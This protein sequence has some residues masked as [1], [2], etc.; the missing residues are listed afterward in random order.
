M[1]VTLDLKEPIEAHG[2]TVS[3]LTFRAPRAGD[4]RDF[5]IGDDSCGNFMPLIARLA[6]IPPSSVDLMTP[7]D[8]VAAIGV[9]GPLL[10]PGPE[11]GATS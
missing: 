2:E 10:F 1:T 9:L 5:R 8:L 11:T 4:M 6:N 7:A 3:R